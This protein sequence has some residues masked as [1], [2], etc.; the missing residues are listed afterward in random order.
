MSCLKKHL[1]NSFTHV[2]PYPFLD[3]LCLGQP[4]IQTHMYLL[5]LTT[6][7]QFLH[8]INLALKHRDSIKLG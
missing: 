2:L 6:M 3:G 5:R 7:Q 8:P 1:S 4:L